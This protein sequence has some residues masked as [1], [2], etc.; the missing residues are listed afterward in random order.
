[1][2]ENEP[3]RDIGGD[4]MITAILI[5]SIIQLVLIVLLWFAFD[6]FRSQMQNYANVAEG[7]EIKLYTLIDSNF[8]REAEIINKLME[9]RK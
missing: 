2:L 5:I 6:D 4:K 9:E 7:Y 8:K 3:V 1:L